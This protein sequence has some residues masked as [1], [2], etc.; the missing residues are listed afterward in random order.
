MILGNELPP[1]SELKRFYEKHVSTF[2]INEQEWDALHD[3]PLV[4]F[5]MYGAI[6]RCMDYQTRIAGIQTRISEQ[7][8]REV[9]SHS[10]RPGRKA[11]EPVTQ[12]Q[13]RWWINCLEKLGIIK[14]RGNYVFECL[15]ADSDES[16]QKIKGVGRAQSRARGRAQ[17]ETPKTPINTAIPWDPNQEV[18]REAGSDTSSR[19]GAPPESGSNNINIITKRKK[20]LCTFPDDFLVTENHRAFA[21]KNKLSNPDIAFEHFRDY[22]LA[23]NR[24]YKDW[25]AAF[26][27]WLR[28]AEKFKRTPVNYDNEKP[29]VYSA[30]HKDWVPDKTVGTKTKPETLEKTRIQLKQMLHGR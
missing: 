22:C 24:K 27:N 14:H 10:A 1:N 6:R 7:Y 23:N 18:G 8:F 9:L 20:E 30:A 16:A 12:K 15:L 5:K 3:E 17:E 21:I 19:Q 29:K 11:S 2:K 28:N 4:L 13:I 26:R 25:D